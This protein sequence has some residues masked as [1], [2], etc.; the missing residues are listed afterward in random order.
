MDG[1]WDVQGSRRGAILRESFW[2]RARNPNL[3]LERR[4][5]AEPCRAGLHFALTPR[6]GV[7]VPKLPIKSLLSVPSTRHA[8]MQLEHRLYFVTSSQGY[9]SSGPP[10]NLRQPRVRLQNNPRLPQVRWWA[11]TV[12]ALTTVTPTL[13]RLHPKSE[14]PISRLPPL[15]STAYYFVTGEYK[16][17][18]RPMFELLS[19]RAILHVSDIT[20]YLLWF[21]KKNAFKITL[22]TK[23]LN[24]Q[25]R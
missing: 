8:K 21:S 22:K 7:A 23:S 11:R 12:I 4:A 25:I 13:K 15:L 17:V 1:G 10:P 5:P 20:G 14:L 6:G 19:S 24:F 18:I 16:Q 3:L 9:D 2:K